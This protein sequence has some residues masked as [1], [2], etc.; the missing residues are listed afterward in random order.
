MKALVTANFT[1]KALERLRKHMEVIYEP[2]GES[3]KITMSDEM[4]EKL[5]ALGAD[6]LIIESD[7]CHEEVFE[8]VQ[9]KMIG[10]CRG[11][12]LTVDE[13]MATEQGKRVSRSP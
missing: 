3:R 8:E 9:L 10:V 1:E 12:P 11:D 13:E 5:K 2:W 6:V 4:A 7:L